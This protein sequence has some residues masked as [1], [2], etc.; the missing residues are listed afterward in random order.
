MKLA[1]LCSDMLFRTRL[2][3]AAVR[4]GLEPLASNAAP[5][6]DDLAAAVIDLGEARFDAMSAI[7]TLRADH[8]SLPIL[9]FASHV[10]ED[11]LDAGLAAGCT[12]VSPRSKAIE[13]LDAMLA[14]LGTGD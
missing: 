14:G 5:T 1:I 7:R 8:P 2:R 9:G 4:A 3:D 12:K 10:R 6:A 13:T 11:L